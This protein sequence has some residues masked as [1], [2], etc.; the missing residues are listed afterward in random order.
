[1]DLKQLIKSD[2]GIDL[3]ISGGMGNSIESPI[4]IEIDGCKNCAEI[5]NTILGCLG[6]GRRIEWKLLKQQLL[7]NG[8]KHIDKLQIETT[9]NT[10][11]EIIT[12]IEN[13]YF[14]ISICFQK[15]PFI[16]FDEKETIKKIITQLK[17]LF[18][19]GQGFDKFYLGIKT[20]SILNNTD[21]LIEF[22]NLVEENNMLGN[23]KILM[24]ERKKSMMDVLREISGDF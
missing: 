1:M 9:H 11:Y 16:D 10:D 6:L 4:V 2:F 12:Q 22:Y 24:Q 21:L 8:E 14:D 19:Q 17:E 3:P 20:G 7:K 13:Y 23:F 15:R 5:E 18:N